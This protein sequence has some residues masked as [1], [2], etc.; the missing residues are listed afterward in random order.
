MTLTRFIPFALAILWGFNWPAVKLGLM[1]MPPFA[2]RMVGMGAG[3]VLL[4]AVAVLAGRSLRVPRG[5]WVP[6]VIAG[7]FN[8]A[9]FN[10]AT[11]FAQLNTS[12]SR[13]AILTFTT[14]LWAVLFAYLFLGERLDR[15]KAMA[16][17]LGL[18]GIGALAL[19]LASGETKLLGVLFPLVAGISWA[20]GTVYQKSHPI[21]GDRMVTTAYQL[22]IAT[23]VA[24]IGFVLAGETMPRH[25]STTVVAA[26]TF[27]VVGATAIAYWLWFI[28][29]DRLSVGAASLTTFAIPVVGVL[30]AMTLV[31][32]RPSPLDYVGFAAI[33]AA[34]ALAMFAA[35]PEMRR[36]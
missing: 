9:G 36:R 25:L 8:I 2:L 16:L 3:A 4:L 21:A 6:L 14:P 30:G 12:T 34:A 33:L 7:A 17:G 15:A 10:I 1:E 23:L 31:G 13:A 28:L 11:V 35:R 24:A 27:H 32:E 22:L 29:L 26:V 18:V 20:A 5:S 19:P